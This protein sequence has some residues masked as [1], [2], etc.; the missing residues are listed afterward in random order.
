MATP[1]AGRLI[2]LSCEQMNAHYRNQSVGLYKLPNVV[3]GQTYTVSVSI[4][5]KVAALAE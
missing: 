1:T 3:P 4:I 2:S 5:W